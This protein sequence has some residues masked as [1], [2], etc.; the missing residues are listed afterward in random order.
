MIYNYYGKTEIIHVVLFGR[1]M[2]DE[3]HLYKQLFLMS[4]AEQHYNRVNMISS[5][6]RVF[7]MNRKLFKHS[8]THCR[9]KRGLNIRLCH[10]KLQFNYNIKC[11]TYKILR[12]L[13]KNSWWLQILTN[14]N[15]FKTKTT[16]TVMSFKCWGEWQDAAGRQNLSS[17]YLLAPRY[18]SSERAPPAAPIHKLKHT[19]THNLNVLKT[20][21]YGWGSSD[22]NT[23]GS[24]SPC[25]RRTKEWRL[26]SG[27]TWWTVYNTPDRGIRKMHKHHLKQWV[28]KKTWQLP[29]SQTISIV[30]RVATCNTG[31]K[32]RPLNFSRWDM[33][34][35]VYILSDS[36]MNSL[37]L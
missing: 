18:P 21:S 16:I 32:L 13:N 23:P 34:I 31:H 35:Y 1:R 29:K 26:P 17:F 30:A 19:H 6:N 14:K 8:K 4:T 28:T 15:Q 33:M 5:L 9:T 24:I 36:W 2:T 10:R 3:P 25:S 11:K 37:T 20:V 22:V 12:T 7:F 27:A